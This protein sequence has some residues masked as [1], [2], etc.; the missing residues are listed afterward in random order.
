MIVICLMEDLKE[1]I[2]I[3]F[4][5][6]L[7]EIDLDIFFE[8]IVMCYM[9]M[10]EVL[11]FG[12]VISINCLIIEVVVQYINNVNEEK[13]WECKC[14]FFFFFDFGIF[15]ALVDVEEEVISIISQQMMEDIFNVVFMDW[16]LSCYI[17][18]QFVLL[19]M[20]CI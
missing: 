13:S 12:E 18:I 14:F 16:Q 5:L 8:G 11:Q 19:C 17:G 3:E 4:C 1:K 15:Q 9:V 20:Y 10:F 2:W 6:I 7:E